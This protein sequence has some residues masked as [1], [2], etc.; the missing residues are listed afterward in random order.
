VRWLKAAILATWEVEIRRI[1]VGGQPQQKVHKIPS[2]PMN[3]VVVCVPVIP[4]I[5]GSTNR[6]ILVQTSLGLKRGLI[7]RVTNAKKGW[8]CG[9]G[10]R[11]PA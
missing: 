9:L 8:Q 7:S 5:Q 2:Q 3:G 6:K 11:S 4:A 1:R 10:S